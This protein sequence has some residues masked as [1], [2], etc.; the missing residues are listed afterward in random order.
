MNIFWSIVLGYT[1]M[2]I[3]TI[4]AIHL[5]DRCF[6]ES[7]RLDDGDIDKVIGWSALWPVTWIIIIFA[8]G[9]ELLKLFS[10]KVRKAI[11]SSKTKSENNDKNITFK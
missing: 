9:Y 6:P 11:I 2:F 3:I 8:G 5:L 4:V 7:E 10:K 1:A